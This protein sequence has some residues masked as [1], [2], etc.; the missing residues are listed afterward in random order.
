MSIY[1]YISSLTKTTNIMEPFIAQIMLFGGNFAPR[2]WA[3]CDGQLLPIAQ[4]SALF[5]LLGT[6]YGGDGRT[7]FAL[8]DL[9]G[10]APIHHGSGPGLQTYRQ[11]EKGGI[12]QVTLLSTQMPNHTHSV[13]T[14]A[15]APV[16]RGQGETNPTGAYWADN[17][18][19]SSQK[20]TLMAADAVVVGN[21]GGSQSHE[22]RPPYLAV[23]YIIALEG[24][25]PSRS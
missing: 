17:G 20:N 23:S 25:Y 10:R 12:E 14:G 1:L 16:G 3:F 9:R 18:S 7:T 2:G 21:T 13:T 6:I 5:S 15:A 11:G 8:P 4:Y 19:Y 24:I 22:N